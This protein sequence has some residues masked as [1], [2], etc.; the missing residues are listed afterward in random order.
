MCQELSRPEMAVS[1][2]KNRK[3]LFII[4]W[5]IWVYTD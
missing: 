1:V 3:E 2:D 5:N 4:L